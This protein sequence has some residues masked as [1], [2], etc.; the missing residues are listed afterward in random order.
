MVR[1]ILATAFLA[2]VALVVP[3]AWAEDS[4]DASKLIGTW[5][6]KSAEKDG[7][8]ETAATTKGKQVKITRDTITCYDAEGKV[9]MS[10]EYTVDTSRTPWQIQM[11]CKEGEHKGKK[12][13]G[14]VKLEDDTLKVCHAKPD[15]DIPTSFKTKDGQ[16]S[17]TL[18]K[19]P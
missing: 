15:G 3:A 11:T 2:L 18:E 5:T 16:C 1:T 12:L 19:K 9:E 4:K 7:K 6:V 10:A 8:T 17:C 14:I 13:K